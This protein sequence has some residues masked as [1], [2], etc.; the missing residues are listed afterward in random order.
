MPAHSMLMF[1]NPSFVSFIPCIPIR[2]PTAL[3]LLLPPL[4]A[5]SP[6]A[7]LDNESRWDFGHLPPSL[8]AG[9]GGSIGL[10][11]RLTP[12]ETAR[13]LNWLGSKS[14]SLLRLPRAF[15]VAS[16]VEGPGCGV[17]ERDGD[18]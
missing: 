14:S 5:L 1:I 18:E 12:G 8:C 9:D 13:R 6:G 15:L 3:E 2:F 11:C 7:W 10:F 4:L 16:A 17:E